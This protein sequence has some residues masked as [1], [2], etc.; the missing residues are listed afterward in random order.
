M[1]DDNV[2]WSKIKGSS[3]SLLRPQ[4]LRLAIMASERLLILQPNNWAL[5]RDHG[6]MWYY[7]RDYGKAVQELS[8][9][10]ASHIFKTPHIIT[11]IT[12]LKLVTGRR[13]ITTKRHH[14]TTNRRTPLIHPN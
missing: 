10:M 7:S 13:T 2:K 6:M 8:I 4:D 5:R 3:I 9:C 12:Q 14:E 1:H 11:R